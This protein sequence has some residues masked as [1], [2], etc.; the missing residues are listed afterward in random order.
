MPAH[1]G[2]PEKLTEPDSAK[3]EL[4]HW[5]PQLLPDG[6]TVLFTAFSTPVER[7]RIALYSLKSG[8]QRMLFEGGSF[9]RYLPTGHIVY[10]R[11]GT[12]LAASFDGKRLQLTGPAQPVLDDLAEFFTAGVAHFSVSATG[13]LAYLRASS[14]A[15]RRRLVWVERNGGSR[16]AS[17]ASHNYI[18]PRLSPD[19][20]RLAFAID[21]ESNDVWIYDLER[22]SSTRVTF[23]PD[24]EFAPLWTPDGKRLIFTLEQPVYD[25]YW[26]PVDGNS[27]DEPLLATGFDKIAGSVTP[28]GKLLA[29]SEHSTK[30]GFDLWLLPLEGERRPRPL[31]Q[32]PF[33]E[34]WP[35]I[36]PDGR[37][38]AYS[39]NES[40][41]YEIYVQA[42]P[43]PGER[44]QVSV[45]GGR[46]PRWSR[47]GREL[48]FRNGRKV[49]AVPAGA[50][51]GLA[52]GKPRVLFEGDYEAPQ[53]DSA[54][55]D[56]VNYDVTADGRRFLMVQRDPGVPRIE[57]QIVLNW[58]EELKRR[59]PTEGK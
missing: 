15:H 47:D 24:R 30:T 2:T 54:A 22:G 4:G 41:R 39:S 10:A 7:S 42:F 31:V 55:A 37:R 8:R 57:V 23:R 52:V 11:S 49:L 1:G 25:L 18:G 33:N 16:P 20:R 28:D 13:T 45:E 34:M 56:S 29:Y 46:E 5:W 58:F 36:S 43:G 51:H 19:G 53:P 50:A 9:A 48:F 17:D 59:V 21:E 27:P 32:T 6:D 35:M 12:L 44:V 38:L 26:K 14:L 3:G 40:G